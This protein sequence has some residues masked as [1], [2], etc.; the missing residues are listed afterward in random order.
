MGEPKTHE[1]NPEGTKLYLDYLD[2]EMNIMGILS[3]FCTATVAFALKELLAA[4][5]DK[6][7]AKIW[8]N[9]RCFVVIGSLLIFGAAAW[10]YRQR[11]DLAWYYGQISLTQAAPQVIRFKLF[12]WLR[13]ADSWKTWIPYR[14]GF[15]FLWPGLAA[16][17][18]SA[19]SYDW[20]KSVRPIALEIYALIVAA[21]LLVCWRSACILAARPYDED[22]LTL[23]SF[24][25]GKDKK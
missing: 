19:V 1:V 25:C 14:C 13:D 24:F 22:P 10:F 16:Y 3:A 12:E 2:K 9:S 6:S 7:L 5:A 11:S 21:L 18:V 15:F 4:D 23:E 17:M 8:E 20:S